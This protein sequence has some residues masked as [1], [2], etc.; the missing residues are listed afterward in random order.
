VLWH[1]STSRLP[2]LQG[3][4]A[5]WP[6]QREQLQAQLDAA[7]R[8]AVVLGAGQGPS[9]PELEG[10]L[11]RLSGQRDAAQL[12]AAEAQARLAASEAEAQQL[13]LRLTGLE[14]QQRQQGLP[15]HPSERFSWPTPLS[16]ETLEAPL[17]GPGGPSP[18]VAAL[19]EALAAERQQTRQLQAA[20]HALTA[21]MQQ[22]Q[23]AGPLPASPAGGALADVTNRGAGR[24]QQQQGAREAQRLSKQL[25]RAQARLQQLAAENERLMELSNDLR[26][27][28]NRLAAAGAAGQQQQAESTGKAGGGTGSSGLLAA[29]AAVPSPIILPPGLWQL[30]AHPGLGQLLSGEA[31]TCARPLALPCSSLLP[32][33]TSGQQQQQQQQQ[34]RQQPSSPLSPPMQQQQQPPDSPTSQQALAVVGVQVREAGRAA[35]S[36]S[37]SGDRGG[38]MAPGAAVQKRP[39]A[40]QQQQAERGKAASPPRVRNYNIKSP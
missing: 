36:G 25:T 29:P 33:E 30:L 24:E 18:E 16:S 2:T 11:R 38:S 4:L 27:E 3:E 26:A 35:P 8:R 1:A 22:L 19:Q 14:Q 17:P 21:D 7:E 34:Q 5:G 23:L 28:R 20:L 32:P 31:A 15:A 10:M 9:L 12:A 13:R 6:A 40:A 37:S 39:Q